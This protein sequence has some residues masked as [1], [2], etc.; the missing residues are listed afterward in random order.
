MLPKC[1]LWYIAWGSTCCYH[2]IVYD[3]IIVLRTAMEKMRGI[4]EKNPSLG[5]PKQVA[6]QLLE[7]QDKIELT[8]AEIEEFKVTI[9]TSLTWTAAILG[10]PLY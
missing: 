8:A 3:F 9:H 4:Y 5:D 7:T 2:C 10:K 1:S 6:Q